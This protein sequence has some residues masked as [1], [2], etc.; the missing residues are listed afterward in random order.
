M[1]PKLSELLL[2]ITLLKPLLS[3]KSN[4]PT[5]CIFLRDTVKSIVHAAWDTAFDDHT[6]VHAHAGV[7]RVRCWGINKFK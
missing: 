6:V 4:I 3:S 1:I 5:N 2:I 7:E